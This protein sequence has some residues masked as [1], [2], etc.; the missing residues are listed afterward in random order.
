MI[1]FSHSMIGFYQNNER[2]NK[3][4]FIESFKNSFLTA[5]R[6]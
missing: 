4:I 1:G 2:K 6:V 3:K 5:G